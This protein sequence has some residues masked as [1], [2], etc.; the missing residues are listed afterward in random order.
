MGS[1]NSNRHFSAPHSGIESD[2]TRWS[3][4]SKGDSVLCRA[5][6]ALRFSPWRDC[7]TVPSPGKF[8]DVMGR[9]STQVFT[10]LL[11]NHR[12]GVDCANMAKWE[13]S[14]PTVVQHDALCLTLAVPFSTRP[15]MSGRCQGC[16]Q[17]RQMPKSGVSSHSNIE[18]GFPCTWAS[19]NPACP[20]GNCANTSP[21]IQVH[22]PLRAVPPSVALSQRCCESH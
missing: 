9:A 20:N 2:P 1:T 17:F 5:P 18:L 15:S 10:G 13:P 12:S 21:S 7:G 11:I 8:N 16:I 6:T 19:R 4:G 22:R 3:P 14:R